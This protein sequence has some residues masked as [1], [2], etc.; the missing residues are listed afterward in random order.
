MVTDAIAV[1]EAAT[2]AVATLRI[3]SRIHKQSE[4]AHRKQA[5]LTAQAAAELERR[6]AALGIVLEIESTD[7]GGHSDGRSDD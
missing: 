1:A 6:C 4:F 2:K 5:K 7:P 3:A